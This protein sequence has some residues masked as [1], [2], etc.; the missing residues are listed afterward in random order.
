MLA[1]F[2]GKLTDVWKGSE[3][4]HRVRKSYLPVLLHAA[5]IHGAVNLMAAGLEPDT[6]KLGC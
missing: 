4:V 1:S 5:E 2:W 6:R 3:F